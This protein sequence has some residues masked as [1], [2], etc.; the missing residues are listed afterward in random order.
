MLSNFLKSRLFDYLIILLV[1]IFTI[2]VFIYFAIDTSEYNDNE[3]IQL[4]ITIVQNIELG[5]LCFFS[6]EVFLKIYTFGFYVSFF[7]LFLL[8]KLKKKQDYFKDNWLIFDTI[9]IIL[10]IVIL[11]LDIILNNSSFTTAS[12]ILRGIFRFLR[13]FLVFRKVNQF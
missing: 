6:I 8:K 4:T 7:F 5:I 12:K 13:M 9:I 1:F 11:V 10:S 3:S 2:I